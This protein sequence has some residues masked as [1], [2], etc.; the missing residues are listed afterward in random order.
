MLTLKKVSSKRDRFFSGAKTPLGSLVQTEKEAH[1]G[2][3][4][5]DKRF[6]QTSIPFVARNNFIQK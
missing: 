5:P 3:K 2:T 1:I 4:I 6:S